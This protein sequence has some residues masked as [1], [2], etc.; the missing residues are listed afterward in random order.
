[1]REAKVSVTA[2]TT[3]MYNFILLE[4]TSHQ[5]MVILQAVNSHA[6]AHV[7]LVVPCCLTLI[8]TV[9]VSAVSMAFASNTT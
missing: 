4:T 1:M 6:L 7:K 8:Q 2:C 9:I 5:I 3:Q